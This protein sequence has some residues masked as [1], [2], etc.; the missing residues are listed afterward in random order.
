[1]ITSRMGDPT[2]QRGGRAKRYV[3]VTAAGMEALTRAGR[4]TND[5]ST[6]STC[7]E[8]PMRHNALK[9]CS[10]YSPLQIAR[11]RS[12]ATHGRTGAARIDLVLAARLGVTSRYGEAPHGGAA[13]DARAHV[14]RH[15]ALCRAGIRRR[16]RGRLV[17][18]LMGSA[19][20]WIAL[21]FFWWG[22]ALLTGASLVGHRAGTRD[23]GV[24]DARDHR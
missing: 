22:G 17:P 11:R 12:P 1:M 18:Q 19:V 8:V 9:G 23:G 5:C 21:S 16:R 14:G 6:D 7:C 24:R 3:T 13:A 4:H 20:S 2:P 10:R 15:G